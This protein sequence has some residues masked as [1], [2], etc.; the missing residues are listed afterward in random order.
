MRGIIRSRITRS[1]GSR[2][3]ASSASWPSRA[4]TTWYPSFSRGN[5]SS[6]WMASSSSTRRILAPGSVICSHHRIIGFVFDRSPLAGRSVTSGRPAPAGGGTW[7]RRRNDA[8]T[9]SAIARQPS[10]SASG[11]STAVSVVAMPRF[12]TRAGKEDDLAERLG[13]HRPAEQVVGLGSAAFRLTVTASRPTRA[14][15]ATTSTSGLS[16]RPW[17]LVTR[18]EGSRLVVSHSV[19]ASTTSRRMVGSPMP[20]KAT[21]SAGPSR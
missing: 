1:N 2:A 19:T 21:S 8:P 15:S 7:A 9:A 17:P 20:T 18:R 3:K 5:R 6:F 16:S 10:G 11:R 12:D 13:E 14:S 4:W